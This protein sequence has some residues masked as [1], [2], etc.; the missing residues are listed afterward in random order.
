MGSAAEAATYNINITLREGQEEIWSDD[1]E[2]IL[3]VRP[4]TEYWMIPM[5]ETRRGQLIFNE[6]SETVLLT[7]GGFTVFH[8]L[9]D[10]LSNGLVSWQ[11]FEV[12]WDIT[13]LYWENGKGKLEYSYDGTTVTRG[14]QATFELAPVPLPS[15]VALMPMGLGALAL[16]RRR[17]RRVS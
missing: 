17:R 15:A 8:G 4:F 9:R 14:A 2:E 16:L 3:E 10:S 12:P 6:I 7:V 11:E 13:W 1:I 5:G